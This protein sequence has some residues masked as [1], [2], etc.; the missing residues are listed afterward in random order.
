[1]QI[2]AAMRSAL[3]LANHGIGTC[4][5][6]PSVGCVILNSDMQLVS[7]AR[8]G[9]NGRPHAE[10]IAIE[11][12]I[13]DIKG[14]TVFV[15]LEP[16]AHEGST[17]SCASL[18]HRSGIK[19]IYISC[20][21]PDKRTSGKGVSILKNAGLEVHLGMYETLVKDLYR[22]FFYRI[23]RGRPQVTLKMATS[24]DGKIANPKGNS[25]WIT[26]DLARK[27]GHMQRAMSDAILVGI[28]TVTED[29]PTL[30]CRLK[31]LES[32]SPIRIVVDSRLSLPLKSNL[33]K[34]I[35]KSPVHIWTSKKSKT[36]KKEVLKDMGVK[37]LEL[38]EDD[39]NRLCLSEGLK[40]L[41]HNGI[42]NLLVEGGG[43]V[44]ASFIANNL[45]DRVYLYRSGMFLGE[46]SVSSV[47]D[48]GFEDIPLEKKF[49][50]KN[51]RLLE[52]DVFE[53][54]KTIESE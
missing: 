33:I 22:G 30:T 10:K 17:P 19:K 4:G 1:M 37:I 52:N 5:P 20:L 18:L 32:Q 11:Q 28:N 26:G 16:C 9:T 23:L 46:N 27:H 15:T 38:E 35:N 25:K 53:E 3:S 36:E 54:W 45:V 47:S 49:F 34:T 50:R 51:F 6:N 39:R 44:S 31:G 42:N 29:N 24:L 2:R 40:C 21:D 12:T 41:G 48:L 7:S 43:Q 13:S 14:G 8:T